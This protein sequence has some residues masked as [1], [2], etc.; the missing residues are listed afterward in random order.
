MISRWK[1]FLMQLT[2]RMWF[3]ASLFV[4]LG[5]IAALVSKRI[6]PY[7]PADLPAKIGS[8]AVGPIL[9]ILASSMLAVTTFSLSVMVSAYGTASSNLT[10]RSTKLLMEDT[11][12]Q[13]V[14]AVFLGT[15]LFSIVG[16]AALNTGFYSERSRFVLFGTSLTVIVLVT[17]TI[18]RWIDYLTRLGRVGETTA[19]VEEAAAEAIKQ[20]LENP[21]LGGR[22]DFEISD[23]RLKAGRIVFADKSGYVQNV[24]SA[25]IQA[26]LEDIDADVALRALPGT[27]VHRSRALAVIMPRRTDGE[28]PGP[29]ALDSCAAKMRKAFFVGGERSYEQDPRFGVI[30]LSEIASRA[31]SPAVNDPGTAIDVIGRGV[32][33]MFQWLDKEDGER[34]HEPRY[35]RVYV[36]E[37]GVKDMFE[38]LFS[39]IAR[40]GAGIFEVHIRLQK[41]LLALAAAG[42]DE[43][44]DAAHTQSQVAMQRAGQAMKIRSEL[45]ALQEIA[46]RIDQLCDGRIPEASS[47]PASHV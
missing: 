43:V 47:R 7:I 5:V 27:F 44:R 16:I 23:T 29:D 37:I 19:R 41:A 32:R 18:L 17:F 1:F 36:R 13:N 8:E 24:D 35:D 14:L 21:Y 46:D 33:L 4:V 11:T 22:P 9:T 2:R 31:L 28:M 38:D 3:R 42:P 40:D 12:S 15:F 6:E 10:P 26:A 39:P 34:S 20:R 25:A 45:T 30:V